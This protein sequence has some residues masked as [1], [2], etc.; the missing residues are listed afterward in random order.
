MQNC[1]EITI[2]AAKRAIDNEKGCFVCFQNCFTPLSE[3]QNIFIAFSFLSNSSRSKLDLSSF[4]KAILL[5]NFFVSWSLKDET[6]VI[7]AFLLK[8]NCVAE[9]RTPA[10]SGHINCSIT[11]LAF[12]NLNPQC[13]FCKPVNT[14][15][16]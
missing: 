2:F 10:L 11:F 16:Y 6:S 8:R 9:E 13:P 5:K 4:S 3:I 15:S 1:M 14:K 7:K 12:I